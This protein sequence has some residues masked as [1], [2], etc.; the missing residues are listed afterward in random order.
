MKSQKL[1]VLDK[2]Y[3]QGCKEEDLKALTK[4]GRLLVTAELFHEILTDDKV[5]FRTKNGDA[6]KKIS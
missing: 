6:G 5:A 1:V 2:D 4:N 3:F